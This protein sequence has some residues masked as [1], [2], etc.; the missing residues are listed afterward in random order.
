MI[1]DS[2]LVLFF[3]V[4]LDSSLVLFW[5]V[6]GQF[7]GPFLQCFWTVLWSLFLQCFRTVLWSFVW[8]VFGQFFFGP[9]LECFR[10]VL[11]S[12][13]ECFWTVLWSFFWVFLDSSLVL[14]LRKSSVMIKIWQ[15]V[16][17]AN[18]INKNL[19]KHLIFLHYAKFWHGKKI[20]A[21]VQIILCID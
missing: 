16:R 21:T 7:F 6:F 11:W 18:V 12:F 10:I 9:F 19:R 15:S 3:G 14:F 4:F 1:L 20:Y 17:K 5:N 8:S 2:S 13:F